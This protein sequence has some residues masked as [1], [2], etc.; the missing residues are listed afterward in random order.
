MKGWGGLSPCPFAS[1]EGWGGGGFAS[2]EGLGTRVAGPPTLHDLAAALQMDKGWGPPQPSRLAKGQG[3]P[4][5]N[6]SRLANGQ[7]LGALQPFTTWKRPPNGQGLRPT[8][9]WTRVGGLPNPD[10]QMDKGW[11]SRLPPPNLQMDKGWGPQ[12]FTT[13]KWTRVGGP[14]LHDLQM[15]NGWTRVGAPRISPPYQHCRW[16]R[17][18]PPQPFAIWGSSPNKLYRFNIRFQADQAPCPKIDKTMTGPFG[19]E[20]TPTQTSN[21]NWTSIGASR[22]SNA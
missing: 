3:L 1:R 7:E 10:L 11:P 15:D 17:V 21:F 16:T 12:P 5:P 13:Y 22:P 9:K 18:G 4:P 20:R 2:R 19:P 14:T 6:L 8:S